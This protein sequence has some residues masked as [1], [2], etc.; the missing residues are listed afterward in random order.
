MQVKMLKD[1][2]PSDLIFKKMRK[3]GAGSV[4]IDTEK[5]VL[6]QTPWLKTIG[7]IEYSICVSS[8]NVKHILKKMDDIIINYCS[9]EL[10]F[11]EQEITEVYRP[12][13]RS[14]DYFCISI[15]AGTVL[16]YRD[17]NDNEVQS[18]DKSE[19]KKIIKRNDHIRL[20][21]SLK[22]LNFKDNSLTTSLDLKQIELA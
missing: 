20:I 2:D 10:D 12:L 5:E 18:Q 1:F 22:K 17:P 11:T 3:T 4:I 21:F 6:F 8:E 19:I 14:S 16:F 15:L 9:K 7:E 13:N